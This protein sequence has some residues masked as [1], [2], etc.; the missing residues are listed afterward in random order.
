ME[1]P[2]IRG[3]GGS[4]VSSNQRVKREADSNDYSDPSLI[5][6]L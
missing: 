1:E 3:G 5:I 4:Q 2:L 6:R